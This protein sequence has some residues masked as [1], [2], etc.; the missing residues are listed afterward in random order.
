MQK[1]RSGLQ[2]KVSAIFDGVP[3][4]R[5]NGVQQL[6][7]T[8]TPEHTYYEA[9]PR[10]NKEH[11]EPP[12]APKRP[13]PS[14]L[15]PTTAKPQPP[16]P[17]S[18]PRTTAAKQH[19]ANTIKKTIRQIPWQQTWQQIKNKLFVSQ[20]GVN[21]TRQKIMVIL[22]PA[23]FIIL[24]FVLS[25]VLSTPSRKAGKS[26]GVGPGNTQFPAGSD[27]KIDWQIPAPYPTTLRDPMQFG[28]ITATQA[29]NGEII[30]RGIVYSE[31]EPSAIIANQIVHKGDKV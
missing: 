17:S 30:V 16:A 15:T 6:S 20:P 26:Y 10:D 8:S 2:K 13:A 21:A 27:N 7:G 4:P 22:V 1:H 9:D 18:L 19:K 5:E 23:L 11:S 28:S 24:I 3:I 25:Q 31:D 29:G 14:H 12:A